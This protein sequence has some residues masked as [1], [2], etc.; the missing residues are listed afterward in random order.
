MKGTQD[1]VVQVSRAAS[2]ERKRMSHSQFA[3]RVLLMYLAYGLSITTIWWL[4]I[5]L[6]GSRSAAFG[7][8]LFFA[9]L[10]AIAGAVGAF[11]LSLAL[12][13]HYQTKP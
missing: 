5:S 12:D 1:A 11:V 7:E 2:V 3:F 13:R 10:L 8:M 4:A 9:L 6:L